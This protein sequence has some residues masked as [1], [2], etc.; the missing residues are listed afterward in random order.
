MHKLDEDGRNSVIPG[1]SDDELSPPHRKKGRHQSPLSLETL[2]ELLDKQTREL[3]E[4]QKLELAKATAQIKAE[5]K[6]VLAGVNQQLQSHTQELTAIKANQSDMEK[7]LA[8]LEQE[9][10][11]TA[12]GSSGVEEARSTALVF[13]GWGQGVRSCTLIE[14]LEGALKELHI[15]G[16]LDKPYTPGVRKGV[17][18]SQLTMRDAETPADL[19]ARMMDVIKAVTEAEKH[20]PHMAP[21]RKLWASVSRPKGER[22]RAAHASK[23]RRVL[24][25]LGQGLI[26][27]ADT[28]CLTG[29]LFLGDRMAGSAIKPRSLEPGRNLAGGR[30]P[31]AWV[32]ISHIAKYA[33]IAEAT[34]HKAWQDA[35]APPS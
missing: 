26:N 16:K 21:D 22:D 15:H 31:G 5:Q 17:A 34:V 24:H 10:M 4:A 3:R 28:E 35:L 29:T 25:L 33:K 1:S 8:K 12:A 2:Q 11:S 20:L 27:Q 13:G 32:D 19:H 30:L 14:V 7:R 18:L 9:G 23:I 6:T